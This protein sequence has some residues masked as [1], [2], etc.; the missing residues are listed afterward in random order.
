M[1]VPVREGSRKVYG[2]AGTK[3]IEAETSIPLKMVMPP[4]SSVD[5][6][7]EVQVESEHA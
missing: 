2:G 1:R 5:E 6:D 3:A 4:L 7:K